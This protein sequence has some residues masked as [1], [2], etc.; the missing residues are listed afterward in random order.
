MIPDWLFEKLIEF[1]I[2][3]PIWIN[4]TFGDGKVVTFGDHPEVPEPY[5]LDRLMHNALY[6]TTSEDMSNIN[7]TNSINIHDL[8]SIYNI[9]NNISLEDTGNVFLDIWE[10]TN[11]IFD[12]CKKLD[13]NEIHVMNTA[14][15]L[16]EEGKINNN[17]KT[18]ILGE[19]RDSYQRWISM[20]MESLQIIEKVNNK[21]NSFYDIS[22]ELFDWQVEL[23]DDLE[24][25]ENVCLDLIDMSN[26]LGEK[27]NSFVG[28]KFEKSL[29]NILANKRDDLFRRGSNFFIQPFM[30]TTKTYR[31]LWYNYEVFLCENL[32]N[33]T[34]QKINK[35]SYSKLSS[36]IDFIK[37]KIFVDDDAKPGGNGSIFYPYQSVEDAVEI[38]SDGDIIYV[39]EGSYSGDFTID[40][41]ITLIGEDM[42]TTIINGCKKPRHTVT[43]SGQ[44]VEVSGFTITN[45]SKEMISCGIIVQG[46][47]NTVY[48]T[49]FNNCR[50]GLGFRPKSSNN[51]IRNN[52]FI[53]NSY[54][55]LII[56]EQDS[57]NNSIINNFFI[58]NTAHG[59]YTVNVPNLISYN[60]FINNGISIYSV[61]DE[62][63]ITIDNNTINGKPLLCL[64]NQKNFDINEEYGQI[65]LSKCENITLDTLKIDSVE[66]GVYVIDSKYIKIKDCEINCKSTGISIQYSSNTLI[67]LNTIKN[68]MCCGIY[69]YHSEKN[70]IKNNEM[71]SNDEGILLISSDN[72]HI[73]DNL[74]SCNIVG[75]SIWLNSNNNKIL[76]NC[77]I[78]NKENTIDNCK[79]RYENN[80]WDDWVGL[81]KV[82]LK[83]LPYNIPLKKFSNFDWN[84]AN[85]Y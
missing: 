38:S 24:K 65:I 51:I 1:E 14:I 71:I 22:S 16:F 70:E 75:L 39:F 84:P 5:K 10:K 9:T 50:T 21:T 62:L 37:E 55:G 45:S 48:N 12:L 25:C 44:N 26:E 59:L 6:Y 73:E 36:D 67:E 80:Y 74:L 49:I 41:S 72:N 46:S 19:Y 15:E 58:N 68:S 11:Y 53:N 42:N 85:Y 31:E 34:K 56:D 83:Y 35:T 27:L 82:L 79:N 77:F 60:S 4:S 2:G 47:N 18:L 3:N 63:K 57:I 64:F 7:F 32:Y 23:L 33:E 61:N 76:K 66:T 17:L 43:I 28:E 52:Y 13:N 78:E 81:N 30:K 69:M 54:A 40:K 20:F 8:L 29:I